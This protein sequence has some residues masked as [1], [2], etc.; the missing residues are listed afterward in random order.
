MGEMPERIWADRSDDGLPQYADTPFGIWWH[1]QRDG[2]TKYVREDR[3]EAL[4]AEN[5]EL[6][7]IARVP[8]MEAALMAADELARA[9]L[10]CHPYVEELRCGD[11]LRAALLAYRKATGGGV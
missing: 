1:D 2:Y 4:E 10:E 3:I 6:R 7:R 5:A 8:D 11:D 9:A